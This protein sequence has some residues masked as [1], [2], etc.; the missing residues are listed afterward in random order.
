MEEVATR[1]GRKGDAVQPFSSKEDLYFSIIT[2]R[3]RT[4][5][6]ALKDLFEAEGS[7]EARLRK[8][9]VHTLM[10]LVKYPDFF[11]ILRREEAC[12]APGAPTELGELR[13]E[14]RLLTPKV[15]T[16]GVR[17]GSSGR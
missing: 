4:L 10:F 1:A 16:E 5:L 13:G 2:A 11:R 15:L 9:V 7:G 3:M 6:V 14:L 17:E 12:P 8:I